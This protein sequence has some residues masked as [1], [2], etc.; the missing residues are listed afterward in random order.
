MIFFSGK[1]GVCLVVPD[2]RVFPWSMR[3][4][5]QVLMQ[6]AKIPYRW[7][8]HREGYG[9]KTCRSIG[10]RDLV[11]LLNDHHLAD[12][13]EYLLQQGKFGRGRDERIWLGLATERVIGSPFPK[14][15]E[16]TRSC[17][18]LCHLVAHFDPLA[19]VLIK[20]EGA[21]PHFCH[22]YASTDL[23]V[24]RKPWAQKKDGIFWAGKL[25][26]TGHA[27]AYN[28][29]RA[30]F[31]SIQDFSGFSWRDAAKENQPLAQVVAEKDEHKGLINLPS[32]CP[33]YTS[34]FFESLA[35]GGCCFQHRMDSEVPRDLA[36]G[37]THLAYDINQ[38]D[39]L[40]QICER[41]LRE[42]SHFQNLAQRG[43][44]AC[45]RHHSLRQRAGEIF[46]ELQK[47][48]DRMTR[49][50]AEACSFKKP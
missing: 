49:V 44:E 46:C 42:P 45:L 28:Q 8:R 1:P 2:H 3:E 5:W 17:A 25:T 20:E 34:N 48:M 14:S 7:I 30:L 29:R 43:R 19:G 6:K 9:E 31:H 13:T 50:I 27:E 35:M 39:S 23:F 38:P 26:V 37:E 4:A 36:E 33:G 12:L 24:S 16:K 22:Q 15:E 32:N 21:Q 40:R 11:I 18:R 10:A 47:T 41:F